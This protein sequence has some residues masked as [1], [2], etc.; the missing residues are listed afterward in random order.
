MVYDFVYRTCWVPSHITFVNIS[1]WI[2][3]EE[4]IFRLQSFEVGLELISRNIRTS[5]RPSPIKSSLPITPRTLSEFQLEFTVSFLIDLSSLS[6]VGRVTS[7]H[8][9]FFRAME[10]SFF[11][12]PYCNIEIVNGVHLSDGHLAR[13]SAWGRIE[14]MTILTTHPILS[15]RSFDVVATS[16]YPETG[17]G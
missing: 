6:R 5:Y 7:V 3:I 17:F 1:F 9:D 14:S 8:V 12:S 16:L 10:N 15:K 4:E 2:L 13:Y 11:L